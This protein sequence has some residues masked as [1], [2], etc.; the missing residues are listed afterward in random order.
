M[1][2]TKVHTR[3]YLKDGKTQVKGV[4]TILGMIAKPALIHWAWNL[5]IK[6][7][8]YRKVRDKAG[9]IGTIVHKMIEQHLKKQELDVS[10]Y[11]PSNLEIA[12][13]AFGGF[14][15]FEKIHNL[16]PILQETPLVSF[17]HLYGGSIDC[18][19]ELDGKKCLL[20]FK[21][22]AALYPSMRVQ[23]AAYQILLE[24][25][26]YEVDECHLLRIDKK[27]GD[28][29]HH[30]FSDL[31]LEKEFFIKLAKLYPLQQKIWK[32]E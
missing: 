3:Y 18:Y 27:T 32:Q 24:E 17:Q 31:S 12:K 8:D 19:C 14:L 20:D 7:E 13:K 25:N 16:V 22:S 23:I 21:S 26:G 1:S 6:G 5:G 4:T 10:D 9:S 2:K 11:S 28:F 30:P 15:N 29:N